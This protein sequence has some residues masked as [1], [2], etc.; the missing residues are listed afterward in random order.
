MNK[1]LSFSLILLLLSSCGETGQGIVDSRKADA[2]KKFD[3]FYACYAIAQQTKE[4]TKDYINWE[5]DDVKVKYGES[6]VY[7]IGYESF[8]DLAVPLDI[9][10]DGTRRRN[11]ADM[12]IVFGIDLSAHKQE[13][14]YEVTENYDYH[15]ITQDYS[16][17][18]LN[19]F[20]DTKYL[21]IN[22]SK[23]AR[24]PKLLGDSFEIGRAIG[25]A[26]V[27]DVEEAKLIGTLLYDVEGT[28]TADASDYSRMKRNL[29]ADLESRV[30]RKIREKFRKL[31]P[32]IGS[33]SLSL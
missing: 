4:P 5:R 16:P 1:L 3:Q 13:H 19:H 28:D 27:F 26:L 31:T 11:H 2:Q 7:Q 15:D 10:F 32:S 18:T 8:K 29:D 9:P 30:E 33:T 6:N 22:R 14:D 21:I 20:L 12:A 17:K 23:D 25:Y 24:A